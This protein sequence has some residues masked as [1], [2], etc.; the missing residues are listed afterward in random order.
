MFKI[1]KKLLLI[2]F[3]IALLSAS[4][5]AFT[6]LVVFV[7][8]P[9]GNCTETDRGIDFLQAGSVNGTFRVGNQTFNGVFY[10]N[11]LSNTSIIELVCGGTISNRWS[12]LGA[13]LLEDCG[14]FNKTCV[15][16]G[17]N[18]GAACA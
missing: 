14:V 17:P 12:H 6:V 11:C 5:Y 8:D 4:I 3:M 7:V 18:V 9:P 16:F 2:S 10:D 15:D 1:T 13:A